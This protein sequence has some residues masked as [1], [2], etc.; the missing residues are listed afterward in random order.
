MMEETI[1]GRA[2]ITASHWAKKSGGVASPAFGATAN[3]W[4]PDPAPVRDPGHE[5]RLRTFLGGFGPAVAPK[6][7]A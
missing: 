2:S 3:L 1:R 6:A 7:G 5:A 4:I